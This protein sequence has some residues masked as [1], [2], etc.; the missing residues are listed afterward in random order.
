M[1][2]IKVLKN[3]SCCIAVFVCATFAQPQPAYVVIEPGQYLEVCVSKGYSLNN[4]NLMPMVVI[5]NG[6]GYGFLL[7][8][9]EMAQSWLSTL[10]EAVRSNTRI[11]IGY[12]N[13][14]TNGYTAETVPTSGI[15]GLRRVY[16]V[17]IER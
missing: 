7:D 1:K 15:G 9:S 8:G 3:V 13:N 12:D 14:V 11:K 4:P 6:G 17:F 5:N 16:S 2:A 10:Q